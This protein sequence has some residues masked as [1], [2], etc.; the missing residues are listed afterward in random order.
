[1]RMV[2][3]HAAV[4]LARPGR[5]QKGCGIKKLAFALS[6]ACLFAPVSARAQNA[7]I[8]NQRDNT[9]SVIDT[10]TDTVVGS[11]IP[12]ASNPRGVAVTSD[13]SKVYVAGGGTVS[14]IDTATNTV[15]GS[16]ITVGGNPQGVAVTPDGRK[17]Y[18]ARSISDFGNSVSVIDAPPNT[19][20]TITVGSFPFGVAVTPDGSKV[21]VANSADNTVSVI[22]T[23]TDTVVTTIPVGGAF[24][25]AASP[26]GVAVSPDGSK[27]YVVN[28]G[29]FAGNG[30]VQVIATATNTVVTTIT[31]VGT[32]LVGVAV[33]PDGSKVYVTDASAISRVLVIDTTTNTVVTS[34]PVGSI[35]I[36]VA[37]TPDGSKVFVANQ[38]SNT[39]SVIATATNTV[40][41]SPITVGNTPIA[42]GKF[43]QPVRVSS[44]F[45]AFAVQ[46]TVYPN[47]KEF[48]INSS[49]TLGP[50]SGGINPPTEPVTLKIGSFTITIP[51]GSFVNA[52]VPGYSTFVGV[53]NGVSLN[54]LLRQASG[55]NYIFG[56]IAKN[57]S[58][59][60]QN[61]V[62][63]TLTI[64]NDT[65]T[66][67]VNAV[68][69]NTGCSEL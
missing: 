39:V 29:Q 41:G 22:D 47:Q 3:S 63:V 12:V 27:V 64:G 18:V 57:V 52:G 21:Y 25:N 30:T 28:A 2:Q 68:I 19:V 58:L 35:P 8:T 15:V 13:G 48:S 33:T 36:G 20:A 11:P 31:S 66:T 59:T 46:L 23:A 49:F 44:G 14:V 55:K 17:V 38:S 6:L 69:I 67:S 24:P 53:I 61:P 51:P 4:A 50:S 5:P 9:V 42:F 45:S 56:V 62:S 1:M 43:I 40:I 32:N 60:I 65:G 7:Y 26:K 34:I 54:V 16:P 10:E 37:V